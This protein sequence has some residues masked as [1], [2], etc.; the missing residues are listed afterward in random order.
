MYNFVPTQENTLAARATQIAAIK[1]RIANP[2]E[3]E[4]TRIALERHARAA[5][6]ID[7]VACAFLLAFESASPVSFSTLYNGT[8]QRD[9]SA[10]L[11]N[12]KAIPKVWEVARALN[13]SLFDTDSLEGF[14]TSCV[15]RGMLMGALDN[16]SLQLFMHKL[17]VPRSKNGTGYTGG[18]LSTQV[19]SSCRALECLGVIK[20]AGARRW[21]IASV[22]L[23]HAAIVA[24]GIYT[25]LD[26]VATL[27]AATSVV[28][29]MPAAVVPDNTIT[30]DG[31]IFDISETL[32]IAPPVDHV[33]I[34][35][36][37]MSDNEIIQYLEDAHTS[38][39]ASEDVTFDDTIPLHDDTAAM[40]DSVIMP[41]AGKA[42]R[43]GKASKSA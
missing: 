43:K 4:Q 21:Q 40:P 32:A 25:T 29:P 6:R 10:N 2:L 17:S 26:E 7:A 42:K 19:S 3:Q 14:T 11:F 33:A 37:S 34:D 16:T 1:S 27:Q 41:N 36:D 9:G 38:A 15:V 8:K 24:C 20:S 12:E 13:G 39:L 22:P 5:G 18:T 28:M 23:F 35:T 30:I 31:E